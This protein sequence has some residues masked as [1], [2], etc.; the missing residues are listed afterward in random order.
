MTFSMSQSLQKAVY[1]ALLADVALQGLVGANVFDDPLPLENNKP[2][3]DYITL[4][5]ERVKDAST[6]TS[7]GAIHDFTV[8][9][10]SA[11]AGFKNSKVIAGAVCDALQDAALPLARGELIY[12]RHLKSR[13]TA[14]RPPLKR[15]ISLIFRAF[16]ED[17]S[18]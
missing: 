10:N 12:L 6:S 7:T 3:Q 18:S 17:T 13:A 9:V 11:Q 2:P 8:V 1:D 14:G 16:V 15:K 5:E 4:G